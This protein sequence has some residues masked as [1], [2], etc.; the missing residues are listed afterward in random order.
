MLFL[1][2]REHGQVLEVLCIVLK[3]VNTL[4][5]LR[6]S[7]AFTAREDHIYPIVPPLQF[8]HTLILR[9]HVLRMNQIL[10]SLH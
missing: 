10:C 7:L 1:R 8:Y 3:C 5:E 4:L 6:G 2:A 9:F